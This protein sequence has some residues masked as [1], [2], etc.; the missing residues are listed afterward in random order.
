MTYFNLIVRLKNNVRIKILETRNI[1][2]IRKELICVLKFL[3]QDESKVD[4]AIYDEIRT[5]DGNKKENRFQGRP[6]KKQLINSKGEPLCE[7][8]EAIEIVPS[9]VET[10][11]SV[12][13]LKED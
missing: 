6:S 11:N 10:D 2:K 3:G 4:L 5:K 7:E 12:N 13:Q 8:L 9:T 1:K